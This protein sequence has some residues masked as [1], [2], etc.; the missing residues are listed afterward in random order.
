MP[1]KYGEFLCAY[2]H[3][4]MDDTTPSSLLDLKGQAPNVEILGGSTGKFVGLRGIRD[5]VYSNN[6]P[7]TDLTSYG[8]I[9]LVDGGSTAL[10]HGTSKHATVIVG[11]D[12][13]V[14]QYNKAGVCAKNNSLLVNTGS[15][16]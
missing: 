4:N 2:P 5:D 11:P 3:G 7:G 10:F 15:M 1:D 6:D 9:V 16:S 12:T 14:R 13:A 8:D